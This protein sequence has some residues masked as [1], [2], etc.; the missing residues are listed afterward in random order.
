MIQVKEMM[1]DNDLKNS[2][3]KDKGSK[4]R[5]QSMN[6]QSR[7]KQDQTKK[8]KR[9]NVK[10]HVFKVKGDNDKSK[11]TPTR[12]SSVVRSSLKKETPT[13]GEIV[14]LNY[15]KSNKNVI[16][17]TNLREANPGPFRSPYASL[18][19][20]GYKYPFTTLGE[21][22]YGITKAFAEYSEYL[23]K[24]K[25]STPVKATGRGKGLLTKQGVEIAVKRISIPKRRI[26]ETVIEEV[27]QSEEVLEDINSE[28]TDE[29]P[30]VIRKPTGVVIDEEVSRESNEE[31]VDHTK[32][33]KGLET[34]SEAAQFKGSGEGSGITLKVPDELNLKSSNEGAGVTLEVPD[35]PSDDSS[36]LCSNSEFAVKDILSDEDEVIEKADDVKKVDVEKDTDEQV[37]EEQVAE[38]QSGDEKHGANQGHNEPAGDAQADFTNQFINEPAE[39]NLFDI[40][41]DPVEPEVKSMVDVPVKQAKPAVLRP[42]LVDTTVTLIL[43]TTTENKVYRLERRVDAMLNF[44]IQEAV[45]KS[46]K[47]RLKQIELPKDDQKDKL[48]KIMREFKAYN[49]HPAHQALFDSITVS[50]N[51]DKDS[52]K[53]KRKDHNASSSKKT[54]DHPTSS[55][56]ITPSKSLKTNKTIKAKETIED[57]D[58]EAGMDEEPAVDEVVND[59]EHPQDHVALS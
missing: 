54:K 48:Y 19:A 26:S 28:E 31:G 49:R 51:A 21:G 1:Q 15:I 35:E 47:A 37:A 57:P 10:S 38:K 7:Y 30:P 46:I 42:L 41:K 36:S 29:E 13:L 17:L 23:E 25:G 45:D 53:K 14:S 27:V 16:G 59:D 52:K 6:E 55:K 4:S 12:M 5:S 24:T 20:K 43:D 50:L 22:F 9:I 3:S 34:L 58:Q 8:G 2:K 39:V 33:L 56:A 44:N 32:K 40:L 11:Q 18:K